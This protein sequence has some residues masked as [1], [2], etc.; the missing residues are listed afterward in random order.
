MFAG[1]PVP[2]R[3]AAL[4]RGV[5]LCNWVLGADMMPV[6]DGNHR[7]RSRNA[8]AAFGSTPNSLTGVWVTMRYIVWSFDRWKPLSTQKLFRW[9]RRIVERV[10]NSASG[11][12]T[13]LTMNA[14]PVL[15]EG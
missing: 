9:P 4:A 10:S 15:A 6:D 8:S 3:S 2:E 12:G 11:H 1:C 14:D 13:T 7:L 5:I